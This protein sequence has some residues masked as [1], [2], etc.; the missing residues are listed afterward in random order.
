MKLNNSRLPEAV[1]QSTVLMLDWFVQIIYSKS[2]RLRVRGG[3]NVAI[4]IF[5]YQFNGLFRK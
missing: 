1:S 2:A 3:L 4:K 5:E